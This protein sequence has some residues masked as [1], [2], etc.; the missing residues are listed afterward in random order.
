[1]PK[2]WYWFDSCT[3]TKVH[4]YRKLAVLADDVPAVYNY[5]GASGGYCLGY[6]Y[7]E[8]NGYAPPPP[9]MSSY[10]SEDISSAES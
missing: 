6:I 7:A 10:L 9:E 4:F 5:D 2:T 8:I 3:T 1:M